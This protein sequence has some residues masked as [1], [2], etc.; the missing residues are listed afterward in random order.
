MDHSVNS[1]GLR[2]LI[3]LELSRLV[4]GTRE[5]AKQLM[6]S[7]IGVYDM[8]GLAIEAGVNS[9]FAARNIAN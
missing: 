5:E 3:K 2:R 6:R 7:K 9:Y 4:P 1:E 8:D